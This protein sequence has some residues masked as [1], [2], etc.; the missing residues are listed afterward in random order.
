MRMSPRPA[1]APR[2]I[3]PGF[4]LGRQARQASITR[5]YAGARRS[6]VRD[7]SPHLREGAVVSFRRP[8]EPN[9]ATPSF[10]VSRVSLCTRV[11]ACHLGFELHMLAD[12][13]EQVGDAALRV[14]VRDHAQGAPVGQVPPGLARFDGAVAGQQSA[15]QPRK[16]ACSGN[17]R[18]PPQAVE[19]FAVGRRLRE[20]S[21][22]ELPEA[23]IGGV[24]DRASAGAV[25]D[26]H[27]GR[28]LVEGAHMRVHLPVQVGA[29]RF[30]FGDVDRRC[31]R[32]RSRS[33]VPRR[34]A[35]GAGPPSR[36]RPAHRTG[37]RCGRRRADSSRVGRSRN[38][39]ERGG[40]VLHA[41]WRR[42]R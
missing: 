9:T 25:E 42:R 29:D 16:S 32:C 41:R 40:R 39:S 22:I 17:L 24:A 26:R 18:R 4:V 30:E 14:R 5:R 20:E 34:R 3:D 31:R 10:R 36:P 7:S 15:F 21:G 23:L 2:M 38:S 35:C 28:Q 6:S 8:S 11:S 33:G 12:V 1:T 27:G 19:Q 13:V 37:A